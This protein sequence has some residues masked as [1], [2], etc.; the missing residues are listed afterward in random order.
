MHQKCTVNIAIEKRFE[1]SQVQDWINEKIKNSKII[2]MR[3][4]NT[5]LIFDGTLNTF[6]GDID[7]LSSEMISKDELNKL[8]KVPPYFIHRF[9]LNNYK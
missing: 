8:F 5:E 3:L 7:V 2:E 4:Y 1:I 6:F 9:A